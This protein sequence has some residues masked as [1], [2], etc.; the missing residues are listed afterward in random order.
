MLSFTVETDGNLPSGTALS[1]AVRLVDAATDAAPV[2][3]MVNCAHPDHFADAVADPDRW[4]PRI[5]GARANVSR[6]SHA[7]LD[8]SEVL[9][10][11]DPAEFGALVAA[12]HTDGAGLNVLGGCCGTDAR[13]IAEIARTL[14]P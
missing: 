12:L 3:Y 7:E 8:D 14:R 11:G 1:E 9:H 2:Y 13:H 10:D 6:L 4:S 5:R